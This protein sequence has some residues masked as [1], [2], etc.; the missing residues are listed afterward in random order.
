MKIKSPPDETVFKGVD[1][2]M[3]L[4]ID[5]H[6]HVIN[7]FESELEISDDYLPGLGYF[8]GITG[9][10]EN[11]IYFSVLIPVDSHPNKAIMIYAHNVKH[12]NDIL[13]ALE[14]THE[15]VN[16]IEDEKKVIMNIKSWQIEAAKLKSPEWYGDLDDDC[17]AKWAGFLLRAEWMDDNLWWWAVS[18]LETEEELDSS[19]YYREFQPST[20]LEA[21]R[22][23]ESS[24]YELLGIKR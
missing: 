15:A 24:V 19:N 9:V 5:Y 16:F 2:I 17:T 6:E 8:E 4:N 18:D 11:E 1:V 10:T 3:E 23:A 22:L 21:R 20:G 12:A 7:R 14:L 13:E